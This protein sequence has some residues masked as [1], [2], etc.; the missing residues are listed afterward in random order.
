M[1]SRAIAERLVLSVRTVDNALGSAYAKLGVKG[2]AELRS[3]F[4]PRRE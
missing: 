4:S 1:A 2:R 3:V